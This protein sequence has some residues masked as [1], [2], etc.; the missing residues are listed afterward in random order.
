MQNLSID[1]FSQFLPVYSLWPDLLETIGIERSKQA[2]Q[3]A[4]DL[5]RMNGNSSTVPVLIYETCGI[6]L[7]SIELLYLQTGVP[8]IGDN[9]V[10]LL[11]IK[12]KIFQVLSE[13]LVG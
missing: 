2:I 8:F 12:E 10:L 7:T 3:Q 13:P 11:S 1:N 6:A 4:L 5:Q 9:N